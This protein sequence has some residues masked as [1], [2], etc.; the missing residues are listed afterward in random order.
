MSIVCAAIKRGE[1][2]IAADTQTSYGS[3]CVSSTHMVNSGKLFE[4]NDSIIGLV[5]WSAIEV[6]VEQLLRQEAR[7]FRLH[8]RAEITSTMAEVHEK[9]KAD[10][11]LETY[12]NRNQPVESS[13]LDALIINPGGLFMVGSYREVNEFH[14]YWAIGSGRNL[15]L[16][17]MH[18]L[19]GGRR[20]ARAIVEAGVQAA[21]EF[22]DGCSL[23]LE[24]RV[25]A[26]ATRPARAASKPGLIRLG[27]VTA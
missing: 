19:Y 24:S 13:Q 14:T 8:S 18:A 3:L 2:A 9:M 27:R 6:V 26:L 12:E 16:G 23:P 22:D 21:A 11:F 4:V 17:A 15:A 10:H 25:I 7:L 1:V 20:S 5:G